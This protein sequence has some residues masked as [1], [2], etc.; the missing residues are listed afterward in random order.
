MLYEKYMISLCSA[1]FRQGV[2][3]YAPITNTLPDENMELYYLRVTN[4][5]LMSWKTAKCISLRVY[6]AYSIASY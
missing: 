3:S 4:E 2:Y 6:D 5:S 1:N